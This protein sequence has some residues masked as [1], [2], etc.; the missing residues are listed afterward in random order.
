M[1]PII[2]RELLELL[3]TRKALAL[4][5]LLASACALLVLVRWPT[6]G[7]GDLNGARAIEVLRIFGYGALA[8]L[9]LLAPAF[10]ATAIVR[11]KA[12]GTLALLLNSPLSPWSIYLGKL[13]GALGFTLL[14]LLMTLP[15]AA[16]CHTLGGAS[17]QGGVLLLYGVLGLI[18]IQL[19]TLGLFIST[20]SQST[21]GALRATYAAVL[22]LCVLPLAPA[23]LLPDT[24]SELGQPLAWIRS[25]SPIPAVMEVLGQGDVGTHG[26]GAMAGAV[27]R[28]AILAGVSSIL[29]AMLT[30]ARLN[31]KLLDRARSA[32]VVTNDQPLR[33]RLL[34]RVFFLVDPNRRRGGIRDWINPVMAKEFRC[35]R[36]GRS[37]WTLRLIA[38]TAIVSLF[39][40]YVAVGSA[41]GRTD[42]GGKGLALGWQPEFIGGMLVF[43]QVA[44]LI[45]FAPSLAAGL[46][47]SERESGSWQ[48]LRMT[49]LSP[50]RILR[51]KLLSVAWPLFL[52]M[53]GTLPGY[54]VMMK[55]HPE[56]LDQVERVLICL[57]LTAAFIVLVSSAASTLFRSTAAATTTSYALVLVICL[58]PLLL[59]LAEGA[60]FGRRT[61][62]I[63][64]TISPLAASLNAAAMPGFKDYALLPANW[65]LMGIAAVAL[66]VLLT[67]RT[68]RLYRP[69]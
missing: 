63:A 41:L 16:A 69:E 67:A 43:L 46:I 5:L 21:D 54:L 9:V 29:L 10:P 2:R 35:R 17:V 55:F 28:Y 62:E 36:F 39:L 19:A 37:D 20:R 11:E 31:L 23:M 48:L 52:L 14:L 15:A 58:L 68:W 33:A 59:W 53:C 49:P 13:G 57:G 30:V 3:R 8:G 26:M 50:G 25:I 47:S 56:Q 12:T 60:P 18:A 42:V 44:L 27:T 66:L 1:R 38:F 6:G 65:W 61:V 7:I 64:L 22:A 34:R 45:L 4:Q 51:G 40:S 24:T 32:G